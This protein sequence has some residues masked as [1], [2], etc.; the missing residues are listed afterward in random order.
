[1]NFLE[2]ISRLRVKYINVKYEISHKLIL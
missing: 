2:D 1:M